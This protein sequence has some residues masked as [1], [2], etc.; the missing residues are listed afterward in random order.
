MSTKPVFE[1][2]GSRFS[3][4]DEFYEEI[5]RQLVPN[6]NWGHNLDGFGDVLRGGFGLPAGGFVLRWT[7]SKLS[8]EQ[9]GH[10]ETV[11]Q[12]EKR[13][14]HVHVANKAQ[15]QEQLDAARRGQGP[16]AFDW[17]RDIIAIHGCGGAEAKDGVEL[18]LA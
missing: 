2:D 5:S 3:T 16:T 14:Q 12:L 10:A 4:L 8:R 1:I 18:V 7:H 15:I 17:L 11:R 13:L 6:A 9:L